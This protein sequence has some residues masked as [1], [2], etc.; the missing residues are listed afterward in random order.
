MAATKGK[1]RTKKKADEELEDIEGLEELEEAVDE[2]TDDE[3]DDDESTD[4]EDESDEDESDEDDDGEEVETPKSKKKDKKK[5][6]K[7]PK[8]SRAAKEGKIGTAEIA[9]KAGCDART[10]RIVL[11]KHEIAKDEE[12]GRYEWASFEDKTVKKIM[13]LLADGAAD[14]AKKE[15]FDK[16]KEKAGKKEKKGKKDKK[17]KKKKKDEDSDEDD[18]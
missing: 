5:K 8:Q 9:A 11:R 10:L 13:K 4:D 17:S 15:S 2:D 14:D 12:S 7:K 1:S 18:E 3:S 6:E 16:L